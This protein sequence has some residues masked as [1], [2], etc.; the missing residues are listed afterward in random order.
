M[1]L[2][3]SSHASQPIASGFTGT[4]RS[5]LNEVEESWRPTPCVLTRPATVR[6]LQNVHTKPLRVL[7]MEGRQTS[8]RM[9]CI[10]QR[11]MISH[12]LASRMSGGLLLSCTDSG[13][14][15]GT[16]TTELEDTAHRN[17]VKYRYRKTVGFS[18]WHSSKRLL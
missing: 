11:K 5:C 1:L 15:E 7:R 12:E 4:N 9:T 2:C 6:T 10:Q 17:P 13:S 14:C 3:G 16:A 8:S 18:Y